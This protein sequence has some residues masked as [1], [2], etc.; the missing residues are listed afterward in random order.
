MSAL[1]E[2]WRRLCQAFFAPEP[3]PAPQAVS[4][5]EDEDED[6]GIE[7]LGRPKRFGPE[8]LPV[9]LSSIFIRR[10][11]SMS[12]NC[13]P[14]IRKKVVAVKHA[15]SRSVMKTPFSPNEAKPPA[16]VTRTMMLAGVK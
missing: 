11:V 15:E 5:D 9:N 14:G 7:T 6:D 3:Q 1:G 2:W 10:P 13:I 12:S 8:V 4:G 16:I